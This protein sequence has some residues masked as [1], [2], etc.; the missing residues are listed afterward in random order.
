[1]GRGGVTPPNSYPHIVR[2]AFTLIELL[3][4]IALV[5]LLIG[6]LLPALA[7][8]REAG[9]GVVCQSNLR[10]IMTICQWY[11]DE[12]KGFSPALGQPYTSAPNW[13]F[14]VQHAAGNNA[15]TSA[16]AFVPR[17]VLV[18][19]SASRLTGA[20]MTRC[21]GVNGTGHNKLSFPQDPD[22]YDADAGVPESLEKPGHAR[23]DRVQFASRT[24]FAMDT[25]RA[26]TAPPDRTASV[27][28]LRIDAHHAERLW[29]LHGSKSVFN[30][31][32]CD[33]SV[34]SVKAPEDHWRDPL[35]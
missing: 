16:G 22:Y 25:A 4:V 20:E 15:T 24:P 10:S 27:L 32:R 1:L 14:V 2:R 26:P 13:A 11:A 34:V 5:A 12:Q 28:D 23:L 18:C 9:R 17:S 6:I 21:F 29:R 8:A 19:P 7:N 35:P 31:V 30:V 3:V 33:A